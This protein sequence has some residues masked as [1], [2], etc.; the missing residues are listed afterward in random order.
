ILA[1]PLLVST[2]DYLIAAGEPHQQGH[3]VKALLRIMTSDL[4][5]DEVDGYEPKALI[6]VLRLVQLAAFY[7]RNVICSS[8]T[9][10]LTVAK[11]IHR[12]FESG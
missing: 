12:A 6:A 7:G 1:S 10:S 9:L 8:A 11:T 5:L 2:I 3:H 4:I